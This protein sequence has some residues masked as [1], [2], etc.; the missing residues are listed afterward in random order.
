MITITTLWSSTTTVAIYAVTMASPLTWT[1]LSFVLFSDLFV[2]CLPL[3]S[4][5]MV[6]TKKWKGNTKEPRSGDTTQWV[7]MTRC[8]TTT[9]TL[10]IWWWWWRRQWWLLLLFDCSSQTWRHSL[11]L[12]LELYGHCSG[13]SNNSASVSWEIS[14]LSAI[15]MDKAKAM[16]NVQHTP[17]THTQHIDTFSSTR[18]FVVVVVVQIPWI[19]FYPTPHSLCLL[20]LD[21][22]CR[23]LNESRRYVS[24][25]FG[26]ST[27]VGGMT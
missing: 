8:H 7:G 14:I 19:V 10:M 27:K 4:I 5:K 23:A 2:Y 3:N 18:I 21:Y 6:T 13:H 17:S 12:L 11:M 16:K 1:F 15:V 22:P 25:Q 20:F 9:A 26:T 24:S